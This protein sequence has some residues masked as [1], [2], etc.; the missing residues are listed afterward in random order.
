M[1]RL[2]GVFTALVTPF[3][4]DRLDEKAL[5]ARLVEQ[6]TAGIAGIVVGATTGEGPALEPTEWKRLL[7][8][9]IAERG[10]MKIIANTGTNNTNHTVAKTVLAHEM[11]ADAGLVITPYY[12]KPTQEGL[13]R[14]FTSVAAASPLP[15]MLYNV[16]S[17]TSCELL[18]ETCKGLLDAETIISLKQAVS[19][20]DRVTEIK[21]IVGDH[22]TI[23]SGEDSL[24][25]PM[26]AV[27]AE[28]LVS[29]TSNAVPEVV[30]AL[31]SATKNNDWVEAKRLHY[32]LYDLNYALFTETSPGPIK[33]ALKLLGRDCGEVRLPLAP[34]STSKLD[35]LDRA[36]HKA[37]G[38]L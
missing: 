36:L 5:H 11:G 21:Q 33:A 12:N 9:C 35:Q 14:H 8:I 17:R 34:F 15:L 19:N 3:Q 23:L 10:T 22:W 27:G 32:G 25:L 4:N 28:G 31:Y 13:Y 2:E 29:V 30:V 6:R 16:P 26:M 37:M 1:T 7:E 38:L 18:P 24:F 20:L